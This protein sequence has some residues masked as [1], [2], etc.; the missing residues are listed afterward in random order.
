MQPQSVR[1]VAESAKVVYRARISNAVSC[2]IARADA[3][4]YVMIKMKVSPTLAIGV[5]TSLTL[6]AIHIMMGPLPLHQHAKQVVVVVV[7]VESHPHH[8]LAVAGRARH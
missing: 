3:V 7:V 4:H 8:Q 5:G 2:W 6:H 1:R